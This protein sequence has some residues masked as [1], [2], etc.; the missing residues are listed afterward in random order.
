MNQTVLLEH[1][2]ECVELHEKMLTQNV[3]NKRKYWFCKRFFD[4]LASLSLGIVLLFPMLLI[5]IIIRLDS[6][7]PAIFCQERIGKGGKTFTIY[8]FRTME[9]SAPKDLSAKEFENSD[10]YITRMGAFLRRTSIDE[11]PQLWNILR[12]DMSLVGYRPLCLTEREI[13]V[14]RAKC[15]VLIM[16]PGLT[17]LAQVNGRNDVDDDE[18]LRWDV[19]YVQECSIKMD[20]VCL[21]KT[22]TTVFSGKGV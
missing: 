8:K 4:V 14:N 18:K 9:I 21:L 10:Q 15:G 3:V 1:G 11:L 16:R 22:V 12:G 7:G 20:L 19:K 5:G 6:D 17:G 13:N 2:S